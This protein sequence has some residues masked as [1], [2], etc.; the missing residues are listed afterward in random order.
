M[1]VTY[2]I[3]HDQ[4]LVYTTAE[5]VLTDQ[6]VLSHRDR[7]MEEQIDPLTY[8]Q[9]VDLRGVEKIDICAG[10]IHDLSKTNPWG[11][12]AH[13]AIVAPAKMLFNLARLFQM[14]IEAHSDD[15]QVFHTLEDAK[16][17][18]GIV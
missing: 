17:Y 4:K 10:T 1:P 15:I 13:R 12:G 14:N 11:M 16:D 9:L 3:D 8:R 2:T 7:L 18:L 5:G 6:E